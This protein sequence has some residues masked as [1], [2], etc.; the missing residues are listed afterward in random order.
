[1]GY[2]AIFG[3]WAH[4]QTSLTVPPFSRRAGIQEKGGSGWGDFVG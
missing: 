3:V 2:K 4:G 1:M